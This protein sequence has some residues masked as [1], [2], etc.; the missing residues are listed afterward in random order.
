M[1]G[2]SKHKPLAFL[3]RDSSEVFEVLRLVLKADRKIPVCL[4]VLNGVK[5][6]SIKVRNILPTDVAVQN[7]IP[8]SLI[9]NHISVTV[10]FG[11][12]LINRS[13]L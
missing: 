9:R 5:I 11:C 8:P 2:N 1:K 7:S 13:I 6:K 4:F 10:F 12:F 3:R